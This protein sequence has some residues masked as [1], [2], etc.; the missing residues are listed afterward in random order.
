MLQSLDR[1]PGLELPATLRSMGLGD[2]S[3]LVDADLPAR[4]PGVPA[5]RLDSVFAVRALDIVFSVVPLDDFVPEA[6][7]RMAVVEELPIFAEFRH[8]ITR[9]AGER[10]TDVLLPG[11]VAR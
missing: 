6:V 2:E 10:V 8:L 5:I 11:E 7:W 4:A 1:L 9:Y 3:V